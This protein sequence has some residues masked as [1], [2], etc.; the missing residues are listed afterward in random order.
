VDRRANKAFEGCEPA[1]WMQDCTPALLNLERLSII[2]VQY[3][4]WVHYFV[5]WGLTVTPPPPPRSP[6]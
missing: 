3:I 5:C 6:F 4:Q 2:T 1:A